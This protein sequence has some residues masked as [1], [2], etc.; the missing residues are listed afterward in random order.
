MQ[1]IPKRCIECAQRVAHICKKLATCF[2]N[3][4]LIENEEWDYLITALNGGVERW[5]I[6][7]AKIATEPD[8]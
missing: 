6:A 5:M 7:N 3:L 2:F 8:D 1:S 4:L